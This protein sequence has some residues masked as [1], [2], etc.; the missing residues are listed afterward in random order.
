MS[1]LSLYASTTDKHLVFNG[2]RL[3]KKGFLRKGKPTRATAALVAGV[4]ETELS[5]EDTEKIKERM[6]FVK[7]GFQSFVNHHI[8]SWWVE[9]AI[10][11]EMRVSETGKAVQSYAD[12]VKELESNSTMENFQNWYNVCYKDTDVKSAGKSEAEAKI[13]KE[14]GVKYHDNTTTGGCVGELLTEQICKQIEKIQNRS[15]NKQLLHLVK[16]RP[17][18]SIKETE[19]M[20]RKHGARRLAGEYFIVRSDSSG[21]P[22]EYSGYNVRYLVTCV[23]VMVH[24]FPL[25]FFLLCC[26][27]SR[28]GGNRQ[29]KSNRKAYWATGPSTIGTVRTRGNQSVWGRKTWD[30]M[31]P[32]LGHQCMLMVYLGRVLL[33]L[34][35]TPT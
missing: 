23:C 1:S 32:R 24:L 22:I 31:L 33:G 7:K 9:N 11:I 18:K 14:L 34:L 30:V 16:S 13:M 27:S 29:R 28:H 3:H 17:P 26:L 6:A 8:T 2:V 20:G 15:R 35:K 19:G 25:K 21:R 10:K 12:M 5:L 4:L